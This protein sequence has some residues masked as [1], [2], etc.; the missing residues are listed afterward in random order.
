MSAPIDS[1]AG[2]LRAYA[3]AVYAK[4]VDAFAALYAEDV[5][6]FDMWGQWSHRGIEAWRTMAA[7]WF[8]SLGG[9]PLSITRT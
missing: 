9:R 5:Q 6:V 7:G 1:I 8:S 3:A 2:V 4:D